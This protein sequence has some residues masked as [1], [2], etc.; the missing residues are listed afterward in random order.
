MFTY[1]T[2]EI[3]G[4]F[5]TLLFVN[6]VERRSV[7]FARAPF[8]DYNIYK[9]SERRFNIYDAWNEDDFIDEAST[10]EEACAIIMEMQ[11]N[12]VPW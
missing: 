2:K 4:V 12:E 5:V 8:K 3:N 10:L 1:E 7:Y 11:E 9:R 6:V